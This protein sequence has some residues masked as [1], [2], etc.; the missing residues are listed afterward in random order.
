MKLTFLKILILTA[1]SSLCSCATIFNTKHTNITLVGDK[2]TRF[3]V[4]TDSSVNNIREFL[5]ERNKKPLVVNVL[6]NDTLL[7]TTTINSNIS[8]TFY[9]NFLIAYGLIGG[10]I[11]YNKPKMFSYPEYQFFDN[12]KLKFVYARP[13]NIEL[14]EKNKFLLKIAPLNMVTN[15]TNPSMMVGAEVKN[16]SSFSTNFYIGYG[17]DGLLPNANDYQN[18]RFSI[19]Q[20]KYLRNI[21]FNGTYVGFEIDYFKTKYTKELSYSLDNDVE[22]DY[23]ERHYE[24]DIFLFN[25]RVVNYSAKFGY[26]F[27]KGKMYFDLIS[28]LGIR[29]KKTI[30]NNDPNLRV[31]FMRSRHPNIYDYSNE[32]G[33]ISGVNFTMGVRIGF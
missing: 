31:R 21:V 24:N 4:A 33:N 7:K 17:F 20:R 6:R 2:A 29:N 22:K 32:I 23:Y 14:P 19:E 25:K 16:N 10:F 26:Q 11:D 18:F 30:L 8:K 5:V 27:K 13:D 15:F 28:G 1:V 9:L 3:V 12:E